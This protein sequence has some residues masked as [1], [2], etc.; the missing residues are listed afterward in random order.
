MLIAKEEGQMERTIL[1]GSQEFNAL[2]RRSTA[3]VQ[4]LRRIP[5]KPQLI[6]TFDILLRRTA[7]SVLKKSVR[8]VERRHTGY[9]QSVI[10]RRD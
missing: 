4:L 1:M 10:E 5:T 9:R 2:T 6:A 7:S 3:R 8:D